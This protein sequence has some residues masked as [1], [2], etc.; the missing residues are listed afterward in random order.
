V[1]GRAFRRTLARFP[2][3]GALVKSRPVQHCVQTLRG[4]KVVRDPLRFIALQLKPART[5]GPAH[6]A[7]HRLRESNLTVFLRHR[8]RDVH[9]FNE[10]FGG[11]GGHRSYE[12]PPAV[13]SMLD[14]RRAPRIIDLGANIGLFGA[15]AF[16]RWPDAAV[17]SFEPDPTNAGLLTRLIAANRLQRRWSVAEV[18]VANQTGELSF[19]AGL[20]ADSHIELASGAE[21]ALDPAERSGVGDVITVQAVDVFEQD[22]DVDLMKIDI[23][24]GEWAILTDPRLAGLGADVLVLE[25]HAHGCPEPDAHASAIRL[26]RAAGYER[27]DEIECGRNNGLLWAWRDQRPAGS[28]SSERQSGSSSFERT[29]GSPELQGPSALARTG[30][31]GHRQAI[32]A[33]HTGAMP[34]RRDP[35]LGA[36]A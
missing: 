32:A 6:A 4:A 22:H 9:I 11:T 21:A 16:G 27:T 19:S 1:I 30:Q 18:A 2:I 20:F 25:W 17:R 33:Q 28:S 12:P 7:A 24:G 8:T 36:H 23:E 3:V 35:A 31:A 5:H 13:A 29:S 15:Y 10:I 26:L 14:V 34:D